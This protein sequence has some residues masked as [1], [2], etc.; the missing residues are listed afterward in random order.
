VFLDH[1]VVSDQAPADQL[2]G[3]TQ[4]PVA[5]PYFAAL[6]PNQPTTVDVLANDVDFEHRPLVATVVQQP[7]HGSAQ[8][9]SAG[10]VTYTPD[11]NYA[12]ADS[13]VY[14]VND[15]LGGTNQA[16]VTLHPLVTAV[17]STVA[18]GPATGAQLEAATNVQAVLTNSTVGSSPTTLTVAS[19]SANPT[20]VPLDA[21]TYFD[22]QD[23]NAFSRGQ[24]DLGADAQDQV[25]LTIPALAQ[26]DLYFFDQ[27]TQA[28]EPVLVA[29]PSRGAALLA[30]ERQS[31]GTLVVVL[32]GTS[33][34]RV[35]GIGGTVFAIGLGLQS[36]APPPKVNNIIPA[37]FRTGAPLL[38]PEPGSSQPAIDPDLGLG[39]IG[40][41]RPFTLPS[42]D[43]R[44]T[45]TVSRDTTTTP[46]RT[47]LYVTPASSPEVL[48]EPPMIAGDTDPGGAGNDDSQDGDNDLLAAAH[49]MPESSN[50]LSAEESKYDFHEGADHFA[51]PTRALPGQELQLRHQLKTSCMQPALPRRSSTW[52]FSI[53]IACAT[54]RLPRRRQEQHRE[55]RHCR[56]R[57]R[58]C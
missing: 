28:W 52:A 50:W 38:G 55:I 34:P 33:H 1:L 4:M 15:D 22:V 43:V 49:A 18:T 29:Q 53:L 9:N 25:V 30:P 2:K 36:S 40:A 39:A 46:S 21:A 8:V 32:D 56:L 51:R 41:D 27:F 12:G 11:P 13:F 24:V 37:L 26:G 7:A 44:V 31:D 42:S 10:T 19:Y 35:P 14:Q 16:M 57:E 23:S 58:G 54:V 6:V 17:D 20:G 3:V 47:P 48:R 45:V 5:A